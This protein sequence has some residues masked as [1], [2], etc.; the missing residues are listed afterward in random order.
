MPILD[1]S[2]QIALVNQADRHREAAR[3]WYSRAIIGEA[4]VYAPWILL[5][6]VG[7]GLS[8]GL[9]DP[10]LAHRAVER[11]I[12]EGVVRLIPVD[13]DLAGR[14]ARIAIEHRI[15]GCDAVYVALAASL[16]EALVTFDEQQSARAAAVV[17]VL[18][19]DAEAR[20]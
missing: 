12:A 9:G 19:P 7:A 1:A 14:A 13:A 15:R 8:R 16:D 11:I 2:V 20:G 4:K 18:R 6:E 3:A 10:S 17:C 5:A